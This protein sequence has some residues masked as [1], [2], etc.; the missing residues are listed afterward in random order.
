[1]RSVDG[2]LK[3]PFCR[4]VC[5]VC[6]AVMGFAHSYSHGNG[7]AGQAMVTD[8]GADIANSWS[9]GISHFLG[10][11]EGGIGFWV[12]FSQC[13][14]DTAWSIDSCTSQKGVVWSTHYRLYN[15]LVVSVEN[16]EQA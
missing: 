8:A 12:P 16:H 3:K 2:V 7:V 14:P 11:R 4:C 13:L 1:M 15:S 9:R 5:S 6:D 10:L